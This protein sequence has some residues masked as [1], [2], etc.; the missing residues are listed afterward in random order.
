MIEVGI[1]QCLLG[2][3]VRFDGGHRKNNF[4]TQSLTEKFKFVS[5]CPEVGI[6]LPVP[7]KPI[8]LIGSKDNTKAV[9]SHDYTQDFTDDLQHY[10]RK[11]RDKLSQLSGFIFC[12]GSPSCGVERIKIYN[13][14][15]DSANKKS[16]QAE[17]NGTGIFAAEVMKY[18][19]L[20]PVEEDGRLNDPLIRDSFIKRVYLYRE[21]QDMMETGLTVHNLLSFHARHKMT[22]LA[23]CQKT[24]RQ[25]GPKL[26]KVNKENIHE[27]A[28]AYITDLMAGLKIPATRANN[29]NVLMHLQGF[30]KQKLDSVDRR[31]LAYTILEY[32]RGLL[33]ILAPITLLKHHFKH[34]PDQ[35]IK[36]LSYFEPY[37]GDLAIRVKTL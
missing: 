22:L 19:P 18:V 20:L 28:Q 7:R 36:Q 2:Q 12:K 13:D 30:L 33:P 15:D 37:P 32:R 14:S 27:I 10:A 35:Y 16:A 3:N 5:F 31:E 26:A 29:A 4:C 34:H 9:Y 17:K 25:I 11:N 23:H 24:Y 8:R 21:W 6:G 1:S